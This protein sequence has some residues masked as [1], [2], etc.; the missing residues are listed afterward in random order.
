[1]YFNNFFADDYYT[2]NYWGLDGDEEA[3]ILIGGYRGLYLGLYIK[4]YDRN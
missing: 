1:M 3:E 4:L 2:S